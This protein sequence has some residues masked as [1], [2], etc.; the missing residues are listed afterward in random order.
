MVILNNDCVDC[1]RLVTVRQENFK[2]F[3]TYHNRPV[4][5]DGYEKKNF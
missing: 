2:K 5:A 3:P 1:E 4:L